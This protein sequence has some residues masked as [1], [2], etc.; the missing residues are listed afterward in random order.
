VSRWRA[1]G[2]DAAAGGARQ[3]VLLLGKG[4]E[5]L[6][7]G[8]RAR[9]LAVHTTPDAPM[10]GAAFCL[11]DYF[12]W[13]R[14]P[15][16][17]RALK[18]RA[19]RAGVPLIGW[20][21]DAP[22]HKGA[23]RWRIAL[24]RVLG[25]LDV[26]ATHSLQ[27]SE[28]FPGRR[29]FL[30]NAAWTQRYHLGG[31]TLAELAEPSSCRWDVSFLGNLD[32]AG[33]PEHRDRVETLAALAATL[34]ADGVAVLL[35]DSRGLDAAAQ[36]E[37]VQRSR[38]NLSMGAACDLPGRRSAGLPERCFGIPA[39]GGFLLSDRREHAALSFTPGLEWADFADPQDALVQTRRWLADFAAL[40]R[41][42]EAAHRRVLREHTYA[43][44][45]DTLLCAARE[46]RASRAP[47]CSQGT[48][49]A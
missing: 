3:A 26:Y 42:A 17:L 46:W 40:R 16:A 29:L 47:H 38:V 18:R 20:N 27:E 28:R 11:V 45:V 13:L 24:G 12:G 39:C 33:H 2:G 41:V 22:W 25:L 44:R 43:H 32:A 9:G 14:R 15:M 8:C 49:P 6:A 31:R 1:A 19:N 34:Q 30:P 23:K 35:R 5:G 4:F 21:R 37:I 10:E 36:V 7:D 48:P